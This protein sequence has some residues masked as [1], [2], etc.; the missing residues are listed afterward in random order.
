[1]QLI[2][3][4]GYRGAGG[5]INWN[6]LTVD[7]QSPLSAQI[8][9][10]Y[11]AGLCGGI[12]PKVDANGDLAGTGWSAG[13]TFGTGEMEPIVGYNV[14]SYGFN[15]MS[16]SGRRTQFHLLRT[17]GSLKTAETFGGAVSVTGIND[18]RAA[19]T[20]ATEPSPA[21]LVGLFVLGLVLT[22]WPIAIF[23]NFRGYRDGHARRSI[24]SVRRNHTPTENDRAFT[25]VVQLVVASVFGL[26]GLALIVIPVVLFVQR[27]G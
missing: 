14:A 16:L 25:N 5:G 4:V 17:V 1:M 7:E 21:G 20:Q 9:G 13:V 10:A 19:L 8:C 22:L 12:T 23:T 18:F 2:G 27:L 26:L 6:S 11:Y 24:R 15:T 3:S